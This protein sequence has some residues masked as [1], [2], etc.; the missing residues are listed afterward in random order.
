MHHS[1]HHS[2][3]GHSRL[4]VWAKYLVPALVVIILYLLLT[5]N[6]SIN[7]IL[8]NPAKYDSENVSVFGKII[9]KEEKLTPNIVGENRY[10]QDKD[11]NSLKI[12]SDKGPQID[13]LEDGEYVVLKGTVVTADKEPVLKVTE[14]KDNTSFLFKIKKYVNVNLKLWSLILIIIFITAMFNIRRLR[15]TRWF[16]RLGHFDILPFLCGLAMIFVMFQPAFGFYL[17]DFSAL[18]DGPQQVNM[19]KSLIVNPGQIEF[20]KVK[21]GVNS[22]YLYLMIF[23]LV[24]AIALFLLAAFGVHPEALGKTA[25]VLSFIYA[26]LNYIVISQL[27]SQLGIFRGLGGASFGISGIMA[28]IVGIAYFYFNR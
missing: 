28:I 19:V 17:G 12:L 15:H 18:S 1:R 27:N 4:K 23:A 8:N 22:T 9:V 3:H 7:D 25:A 5:N 16:S 6:D 14:I 24:L 21:E 10:I 26:G 13:R 20:G 2:S 11:G